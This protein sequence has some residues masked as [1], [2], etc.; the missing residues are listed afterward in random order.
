MRLRQSLS[1]TNKIMFKQDNMRYIENLVNLNGY[2]PGAYNDLESINMQR[3]LAQ[4]AEQ[5]EQERYDLN[6]YKDD[7]KQVTFMQSIVEQ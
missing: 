1:N 4:L 5:E 2:E 3:E 6:L 7:R